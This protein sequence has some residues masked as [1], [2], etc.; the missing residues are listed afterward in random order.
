MP[1]KET[2]GK[3]TSS[4]Q[5]A[6]TAKQG[7]PETSRDPVG[8]GPS[9]Q[10]QRYELYIMRHGIAVARGAEF[11]DDSKRPLTPEGKKKVKQIASG[12]KRLG[13]SLDWVVTSPLVRAVETAEIVAESLGPNVQMDF[14][15]A[16]RPGG[17]AESLITFLAKHPN[18]KR[19]LVAGHE[20][21]LGSLAARLIG[22]GRHVNLAFKKGGC[23]L[24]EF[25]QFPP[26]SPGD[27]VWWATPRLLR[28][29][30]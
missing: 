11:E 24:L 8:T 4:T 7:P 14:C 13:V 29:L 3:E 6:D 25:D 17:S 23:C 19:I 5:D 26:K 2:A 16:L 10:G 30:G 12:L 21:D 18:R 20:P 28:K 27:L 22:A 1:R 15:D 9:G